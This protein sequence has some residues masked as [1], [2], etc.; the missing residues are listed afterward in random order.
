MLNVAPQYIIAIG[1]SAG[2]ME[3]INIFFD[4]TPLDGVAYVI[5]QHLSAEFKSRMVELLAKHSKLIVNEAKNGVSIKSNEVYLIPHNKVMIIKNG[6]LFLTDKHKNNAPHLTINTFLHSLAVD[7]G[8]KSI[9]VILSGLGS[10]GTEGVRSIKNAGGMIIARNPETTQFSS[11]PSHAIATGLVDFIL[12]PETMPNAIEDYV[13]HEQIFVANSERE[14]DTINEILELIRDSSP[15]DFSDYKKPTILRRTKRRAA[16]H[17]IASL[18]EYLDFLRRTPAE[19]EALAKDYLISVT[20]FF[21][22]KEAFLQIENNVIPDLLR[23]HKP[24]EELKVWV[25]GCA[26]GEEVYSLAIIL[27]ELLNQ[28][29]KDV[30]VKIFA[31]DVDSYALSYAGKGIYSNSIEN[32]VSR[33]RLEKHFVKDGDFYKI[34]ADLRQ[35]VI[36]AQHDLVKNPPYCNMD[37]VSCRNLLIYMTPL[38]QQKVLNMLRFGLKKE[39]YLFLG[40]SENAVSILNDLEVVHKKW[41][42]YKNQRHKRAVTFETFNLPELMEIHKTTVPTREI[43][44]NNTNQTLAEAIIGT[45]AK[46]IGYV[47]ICVD[48]NHRVIK[49]YGNSSKYL[50]QENFNTNLPELLPKPLAIVYN[51]LFK[52]VSKTNQPASVSN[53]IINNN[54]N[55]ISVDISI[56]SL[57]IKK[58]DPRLFLAVFTDT[59]SGSLASETSKVFNEGIYFDEYTNNLEEELKELKVKLSSAYELLDASNENM[60]SF[61]EELISANEEMQST[62]E[63]MQSVNEELHTINTD[64]QLKNKEL[65]ELNDDLNNYFRSNINGQLFVDNNLVVMKFSPGTLKLFNLS[66]NDTGRSLKTISNNIK[67]DT[68]IPDIEKVILDASVINKEIESNNGSW[69]QVTIMPYLQLS[70]NKQNGAIITFNDVTA[71]KKA[72]LEVDKKNNSL[73][74][75]NADL[76]NFAHATSHDL[77]GPL[78][79]IELSINTI[80]RKITDPEM[81][82]FL[83]IINSSVRKFSLMIKEIGTVAKIENDR[84]ASEMVNLDE[85]IDNIE[86]SL[87]NKIEISKAVILRNFAVKDILFSKKNLRSILYNLIS[88]AI[89]YRSERTPVILI[90]TTLTAEET[91]LTIEDNGKGI[92]EDSISKVFDIYSRLNENIEGTGIGLYLVKKIINAAGGSISVE[93]NVNQGSKF[94]LHFRTENVEN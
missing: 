4:H 25:A 40:S 78:N 7:N 16:F 71:L 73:M 64:Y 87:E 1:A 68:I 48:E 12:E 2:G 15:L 13:K 17:H 24:G 74:R 23:R 42:I 91:V 28:E 37:L 9:A 39:G 85:L 54:N 61:N 60:Q 46:E 67:I 30:V 51:T 90:N 45:L 62:N 69:Y 84:L 33:E 52:D 18:D 19:A 77:I 56:R 83:T 92:P 43:V 8:R 29:H 76:D 20:S 86:W 32:D 10:D 41:R 35:M 82:R 22:D 5:V 38:L 88:N 89:K 47:A 58:G 79:N 66:E 36:F 53:I 63:E 31:T 27:Y 11:M 70:E 50:R 44:A 6:R 59:E 72:H 49:S 65:L 94:T 21:R 93:S 81:N 57:I 55:I 80:N 14:E 26:T 34:K 3:E 75:I